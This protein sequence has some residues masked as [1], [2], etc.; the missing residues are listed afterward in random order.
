M[1]LT[2]LQENPRRSSESLRLWTP[3]IL[4]FKVSWRLQCGDFHRSS[5][6]PTKLRTVD[7]DIWIKFDALCKEL[8]WA[9]LLELNKYSQEFKWVPPGLIPRGMKTQENR[10]LWLQREVVHF[11]KGHLVPR[12]LPAPRYPTLETGGAVWWIRSKGD[13]RSS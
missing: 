9:G 5:T 7:I 11:Q 6:S 4:T 12:V 1:L 2:Y 13:H 3:D 8:N 10:G